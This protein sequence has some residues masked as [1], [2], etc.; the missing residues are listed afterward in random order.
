VFLAA[1]WAGAR[2]FRHASET[3]YRRVAFIVLTAIALATLPL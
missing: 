2:S 1:A 3:F